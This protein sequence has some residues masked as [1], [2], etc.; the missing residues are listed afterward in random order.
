MNA[1]IKGK[2]G[3]SR[4]IVAQAYSTVRVPLSTIRD[5]LSLRARNVRDIAFAMKLAD[6]SDASLT[7]VCDLADQVAEEASTDTF[8]DKP[9]QLARLLGLIQDDKQE[10]WDGSDLL[11]L[12]LQFADEIVQLIDARA[13]DKQQNASSEVAA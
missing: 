2:A 6:R 1:A 8:S 5:H 4:V 9:M 11:D 13:Q 3:L 7:L 10:A 12:A